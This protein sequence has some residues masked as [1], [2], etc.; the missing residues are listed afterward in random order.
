[1]TELAEE[2][3]CVCGRPLDEEQRKEIRERAKHYLGSDD[4]AFL[5]ALK[6]DISNLI[7]PDVAGHA[8]DLTR[9]IEILR[10]AIRTEDERRTLY[11]L[12]E[13]DAVASDPALQEAKGVI[14]RIEASI[15]ELESK[16]QKF[17]SLDDSAGDENTFGIR[18]LERRL[19]DAERKLAEITKTLTMR[20][21]MT[22][23]RGIMDSALQKAKVGI[24]QEICTQTNSRIA[25]VM[26]NNSIRVQHV[27]RCLILEGQEGGSA[28]E[29]L[30]V[31]YA[32]L[33]TLFNRVEHQ[34][35]FIV[36]SPANPIDLRVRAKIAELIP[37]LTSQFV[38]FTISSERQGFV[39]PLEAACKTPI[40]YVTLFRRGDAGMEQDAS[41][42]AGSVLTRDGV[43]VTG[44][45]F[46]SGFHIEKED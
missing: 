19:D 21:K 6:S 5:N 18:I 3:Q 34:L 31:A 11:T 20:R 12:L 45:E 46:F 37:Q 38:A 15:R 13:N 2:P 23:L 1:M 4:V 36:D 39:G 26:P 9:R 29:T 22:V 32:F 33:A 27:D 16:R 40:N 42:I 10:E 8:I 30:S 14:D 24:S 35:P 41:L 28:G 7:G 44:G 17:E 43:L 25:E